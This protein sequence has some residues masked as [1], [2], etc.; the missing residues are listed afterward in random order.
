MASHLIDEACPQPILYDVS[1]DEESREGLWAEYPVVAV[2]HVDPAKHEPANHHVGL[3]RGHQR[4]ATEQKRPFQGNLPIMRKRDQRYLYRRFDQTT[5][6]LPPLVKP[7]GSTAG[8][9]HLSLQAR[10]V[11]GPWVL[12]SS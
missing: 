12:K 10:L 1:S 5:D 3:N 11:D 4:I 6:H 9:V 7:G 8:L 2:L